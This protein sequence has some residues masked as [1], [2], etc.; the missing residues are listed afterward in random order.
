MVNRLFGT[1]GVRGVAGEW[2]LDAPTVRRL[3]ASIA[4]LAK[5]RLA[6]EA[7]APRIILGRD[8]RESGE[9]IANEFARGAMALTADV[10]DA[11]VLPTPGVA[12]LV[13]TTP[14]D[15][16]VVLSASHNPF[17]D[18]GIK[19]FSGSGEK[20]GDENERRVEQ[21]V[22][23]TGWSVADAPAVT[24]P[25]TLLV[26][27]YL[28]YLARLLPSRGRLE[29]ARLAIDMANGATTATADSLFRRLG[30]DVVA[31]GDSNHRAK[32]GTHGKSCLLSFALYY[33]VL[34][35]NLP[36]PSRTIAGATSRRRGSTIRN[37]MIG[38]FA[39]S[40]DIN[41]RSDLSPQYRQSNRRL[42]P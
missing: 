20:F 9:W 1:D 37:S 29:G 18:N 24:V 41:A 27:P 15:L 17:G 23:D 2:P 8:T 30:F 12:F 6:H 38:V 34:R 7:R 26:E 4:M 42:P 33:A 16:G 39:F 22:G 28:E 36:G 32:I 5:E 11:G 13:R 14:F 21:L 35:V 10:T 40:L 19:V 31:A 3:G 25:T